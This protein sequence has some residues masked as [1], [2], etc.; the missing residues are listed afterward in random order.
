MLRRSLH[1]AGIIALVWIAAAPAIGADNSW[2]MPNLNPFSGTGKSTRS[3]ASNAPTSG[4]KMPKLWPSTSGTAARPKP[5]AS[6]QPSTWNKMTNGTQQ[7]F[8]KTADAVNPW[9]NKKPA[10]PPKL[11]GSNSIFTQSTAKEKKSEGVAPAS[12]WGGEKTDS[13]P[14]TVNDFLSR[15]RP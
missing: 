5:K 11:T 6:N 3:A 2:K 15:P 13:Q 10:P 8:S 9:D 14:K 12:W 4:W 1:T 7:L